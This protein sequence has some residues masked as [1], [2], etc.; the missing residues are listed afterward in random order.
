[1]NYGVIIPGQLGGKT[2][3]RNPLQPFGENGKTLLEWKINQVKQI[4]SCDDIFV[5]SASS[6]VL[7]IAKS[8]GGKRV[9]KRKNH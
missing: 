4:F 1:M 2:Y 9:K 3:E 5:S 7:E 6:E 8:C